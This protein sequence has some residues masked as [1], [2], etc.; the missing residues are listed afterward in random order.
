MS[1]SFSNIPIDLRTPGQY[2]E[3]DNSAAVQGI[4]VQRQRM[5]V[6]GQRLATGTAQAGELVLISA[7][8]QAEIQFGRG[9][10]L[11][12]AAAAAKTANPAGELWALALND[13]AG[14]TSAAGSL[15]FTGTAAAAGTVALYVAGTRV[16]AAVQAGFTAAQTASAVNAA[17]SANTALPV[18]S[19]VDGVDTTKINLTA[20]NKGLV[21]NEIDVRVNYGLGERLPAGVTLVLVAMTGGAGNPD[22]N[23]ALA[24]IAGTQYQTIA[25]PWTDPTNLSALETELSSRWGPL[26]MQEGQA[27][28]AEPGTLGAM[29]AL[30][31]SRNSAFLTLVGAGKSPTP[32]Y[33]TAAV[34]AAIDAGEPDPARPRQ[35]LRL[36]GVLAPAPVD[37]LS[38]AERDQ[39][40]HSGV[41][42]L[43]A[44]DGGNVSIE[45]LI[46]TYQ[47]SALGLPDVSF[48][49]IE[50]LRT[51]AF[52]RFSVRARIGLRFP[53]HKLADDGTAFAPGQAIVTS[54][55]IRAELLHLFRE[56]E[57]A[58][59]VEGFE[60]FKRDLIVERNASDPNRVDSLIPPDVVNQFRVFAAA[61]QFR[62]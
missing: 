24:A 28:A 40:L 39:L 9:S 50:T 43:V 5:L 61:V 59:L 41:S 52:L 36:P 55:L 4:A 54:S 53:R 6:L 56:W 48:L 37:R 45:R 58:G 17:I 44:D 25:T 19:A 3:I 8:G 32:A 7:A 11:A 33:V 35:T 51:L 18:T 10:Q 31:A 12:A 34:A 60:Q 14:G 49:D 1:I 38:R 30:G 23:V 57:S 15:T 46:T 26:V 29:L 2:I 42:T 13:D 20:R 27:F 62:L 21:G 16:Q 47:T 22:I